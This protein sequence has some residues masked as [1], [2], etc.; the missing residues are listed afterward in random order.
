MKLNLKSSLYTFDFIGIIPELHIFNYNRYKSIFSS[1]NSIIIILA[2]IIFAIYSLID[3]INQEPLINY[4]RSND[5]NTN[6]TIFLND[7]FLMFKIDFL[8]DNNNNISDI[9]LK[10]YYTDDKDFIKLFA[11]PCEL[12]KN[13]NL[14]YKNLIKNLEKNQGISLNEYFCINSNNKNLSLFYNPNIINN[15]ESKIELLIYKKKESNYSNENFY[16]NILTENDLINHNNKKEPITPYFKSEEFL[17]NYDS[18]GT[19]LYYDFQYIKYDSDIG[20]IFNNLKNINGISFS[21]ISSSKDTINLIDNN[22]LVRLNFRI[23][24]SNFDVYKRNYQ[25]VPSLLANIMSVVNLMVTISRQISYILL[26][27]EMSKE[28][29][30]SLII[31]K[32]NKG[33]ESNILKSNKNL[34]IFKNIE[35]NSKNKINLNFIKLNYLKANILANNYISDRKD[36]KTDISGKE[37][38][39][40]FKNQKEIKLN[41]HKVNTFI[42]NIQLNNA[43]INILKK[44][45]FWNILKSF[46]CFKDKKSELINICHNIIFEDICIDSIIKRL[47]KLENLFLMLSDDD[48][49]TMKLKINKDFEKLNKCLSQ[50]INEIK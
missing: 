46:F 21:S 37:S 2:S 34:N 12:G 27:K 39:I 33:G 35:D 24:K 4:Y 31:K 22:L 16:L 11:E 50:I 32:E 8:N 26:N 17:F 25:K 45:N 28:I 42:D 13:I 1:I 20:I 48:Y 10:I 14:K 40:N 15:K 29:I 5:F 9:I 7:I 44:L 41:F 18:Q 36:I 23:N 30:K 43:K 6:R 19:S 3:F 47:Y 49:S 38:E